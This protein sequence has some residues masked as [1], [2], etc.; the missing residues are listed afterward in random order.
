MR[1]GEPWSIKRERRRLMSDDEWRLWFAWY[2][3][4][5][6]DNF[7]WVWLERVEYTQ[8]MRYNPPRYRHPRS[9]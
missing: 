3:V 1:Y 2:P 6:D 7:T 9:P 8:P 5:T 4:R